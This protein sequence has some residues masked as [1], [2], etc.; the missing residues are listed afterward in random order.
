MIE[1]FERV[2][3]LAALAWSIG[4][5]TAALAAEAPA[6]QR[7]TAEASESLSELRPTLRLLAERALHAAFTP[8]L[9]LHAHADPRL[10]LAG[11]Q[12]PTRRA[13][14]VR[15][16]GPRLDD[17]PQLVEALRARDLEKEV[18]GEHGILEDQLF[19]LGGE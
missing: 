8:Y 17:H 2:A 15:R 10:D 9:D 6:P 1:R 19:D 4:L 7:C 3:V 11:E 18:G 12:A 13:V 14:V 5:G 16:A